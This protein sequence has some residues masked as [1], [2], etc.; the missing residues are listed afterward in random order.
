MVQ[1]VRIEKKKKKKKKL[2]LQSHNSRI[3]W[4]ALERQ[5]S[6]KKRTK[7]RNIEAKS[8][9]AA[10]TFRRT[11]SRSHAVLVTASNIFYQLRWISKSIK[12]IA[13]WGFFLS[14][15]CCCC[16]RSSVSCNSSIQTFAV[17]LVARCTHHTHTQTD[18]RRHTFPTQ[19][20]SRQRALCYEP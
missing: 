15:C 6:Q 16:W 14:V 19:F 4:E 18:S 5:S 20:S 1:E 2:S 3:E 10:H 9:A 7:I 12:P 13:Y 11:T 8:L 17:A